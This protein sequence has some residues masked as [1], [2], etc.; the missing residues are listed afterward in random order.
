MVSCRILST[1]CLWKYVPSL[2][3]F[4]L[5]LSH[6][7]LHHDI[8]SIM[9]HIIF[10]HLPVFR[11]FLLV[12]HNMK[13]HFPSILMLYFEIS[14]GL[15]RNWQSFKCTSYIAKSSLDNVSTTIMYIRSP[16][17]SCSS[18]STSLFFCPLFL[19][20]SLILLTRRSCGKAALAVTA[21]TSI[22]LKR[23]DPCDAMNCLHCAGP[24]VQQG[25]AAVAHQKGTNGRKWEEGEKNSERER[26]GNEKLNCDSTNSTQVWN[27]RRRMEVRLRDGCY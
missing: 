16:P 15:I 8:A 25:L 10:S 13:H 14:R 5:L 20:S 12:T 11:Y 24:H 26:I 9:F 22:T 21:N 6:H 1:S 4:H 18:S 2:S 7:N 17:L 23:D 27:V 19:I 3:L